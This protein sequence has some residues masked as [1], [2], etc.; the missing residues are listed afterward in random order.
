MVKRNLPS[1]AF[2]KS[3]GHSDRF[4]KTQII[5]SAIKLMRKAPSRRL[6]CDAVGCYHRILPP[7]DESANLDY[8]VDIKAKHLYEL[9]LVG[10]KAQLM[11]ISAFSK[12]CKC[13]K[14]QSRTKLEL[15]FK[16]IVPSG[17]MSLE[18]FF[19]ALQQLA[20]TV[21]GTDYESTVDQAL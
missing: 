6:E 12:L 17:N 1:G 9:L 16:R 20:E 10:K 19:T 15:L 18:N 13:F 21:L 11:T 5:Q 7:V 14:T 2:E 3:I 4:I 8:L